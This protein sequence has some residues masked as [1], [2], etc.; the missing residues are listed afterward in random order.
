M[1]WLPRGFEFLSGLPEDKRRRRVLV[2]IQAFVDESG[3][4]ENATFFCMSAVIGRAEDWAIFSDEWQACLDA[5]PRIKYFKMAEAAKLRG[6]FFGLTEEQ[7]DNK[8][9]ALRAVLNRHRRAVHNTAMEKSG[10]EVVAYRVKPWNEPYFYVYHAVISLIA[11]LLVDFGVRERFEIIFD[12]QVIFGQRTKEWYAATCEVTKLLYP[13]AHA[14]LPVE[15]IFR[16]DE[17]WLPLQ[18]ADLFAWRARHAAEHPNDPMPFQWTDTPNLILSNYSE[19]WLAHEFIQV[20]TNSR[21][22]AANPPPHIAE[23]YARARQLAPPLHQ[24]K[25]RKLKKPK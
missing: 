25:K 10:K 8:L 16:S 17:E 6:Q 19:K 2:V 3:L 7:R 15:P 20:M 12:E 23:T 9:R 13:Q 21:A 11:R 14:I 5:Y 22:L 4:D 24:R 1:S 18:A